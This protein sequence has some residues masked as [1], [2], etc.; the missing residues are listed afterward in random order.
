MSLRVLRTNKTQ[1]TVC[2]TGSNSDQKAIMFV[3][4]GNIWE[5]DNSQ[6]TTNYTILY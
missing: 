5:G 2:R 1:H 4:Q 3:E 6:S